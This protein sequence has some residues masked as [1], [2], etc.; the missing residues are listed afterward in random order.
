MNDNTNIDLLNSSTPKNTLDSYRPVAQHLEDE[1]VGLMTIRNPDRHTA[2]CLTGN[3]YDVAC[4]INRVQNE[5]SDFGRESIHPVSGRVQAHHKHRL[6]N[7]RFHGCVSQTGE[8]FIIQQKLSLPGRTNPWNDSKAEILTTAA[9][10][11]LR[12]RSDRDKQCYTYEIVDLPAP[13]A[14]DWPEFEDVLFEALSENLID[15]PDH[16]LLLPPKEH[17]RQDFTEWGALF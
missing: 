5:L 16:P 8:L 10:I 1:T 17:Q 12:M 7:I 3:S 15:S 13:E 2:F 14:L 9:G 6:R 11:W 4:I